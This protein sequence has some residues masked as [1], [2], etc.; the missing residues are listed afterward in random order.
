MLLRSFNAPLRYSSIVQTQRTTSQNGFSDVQLCILTLT[1]VCK[2]RLTAR[3]MFNCLPLRLWICWKKTIFLNMPNTTNDITNVL[4]MFN[5]VSWYTLASVC[6]TRLTARVNC[7]P[8]RL[9]IW[10]KDDWIEMTECAW[11]RIIAV[12]PT[13][14]FICARTFTTYYQWEIGIWLMVCFI[15]LRSVATWTKWKLPETKL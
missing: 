10:C 15:Q 12:F 6:K 3:V 5:Y 13:N 9:I 4:V 7:L 8:S 1:S 14:P 11:R 2:T